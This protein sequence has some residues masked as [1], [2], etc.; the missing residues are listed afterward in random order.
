M[1]INEHLKDQVF[2]IL[3]QGLPDDIYANL[4][5]S[6][7]VNYVKGDPNEAVLI[8]TV[9]PMTRLIIQHKLP[10]NINDF[11]AKIVHYTTS[12]LF[13]QNNDLTEYNHY[14]DPEATFMLDILSEFY[15]LYFK[16][17]FEYKSEN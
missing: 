11:V 17:K 1:S 2:E 6:K 3:S 14:P 8:R 13:L 16:E 10:S 12:R 15:R 5:F 7:V 4:I 9:L